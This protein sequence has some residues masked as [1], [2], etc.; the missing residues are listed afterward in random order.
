M[1]ASTLRKLGG[2]LSNNWEGTPTSL[3]VEAP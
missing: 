2:K 1:E 3:E